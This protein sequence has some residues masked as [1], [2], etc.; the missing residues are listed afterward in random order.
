MNDVAA[1]LEQEGVAKF[2]AAFSS[3]LAALEA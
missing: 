2:Q 3:M 1:K